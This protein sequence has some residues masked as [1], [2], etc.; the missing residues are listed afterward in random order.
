MK[1]YIPKKQN[2]YY[3]HD[4]E[5][6]KLMVHILKNYPKIKAKA[7]SCFNVIVMY[8]N[9]VIAELKEKYSDTFTGEEFD[10]YNAFMDYSVFCYYRSRPSKDE[11]PSERTW[12]YYRSEV[13]Y[14][15]A[16]KLGCI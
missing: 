11:A 4:G 10:A 15:L 16:K 14:M 8:V 5:T 7:P 12:R 9:E 1:E 3:I 2:R 13:V 6:Y